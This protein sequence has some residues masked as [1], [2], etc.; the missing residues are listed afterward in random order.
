MRTSKYAATLSLVLGALVVAGAG[1]TGTTTTTTN[2]TNT[3]IDT[4][5]AN[6]TATVNSSDDVVEDELVLDNKDTTEVD[7][8][9]DTE[10]DASAA[11]IS[12]VDPLEGDT[13]PPSFDIVVAVE[14]F[15]LAPDKVEGEN[16][17]GEGH[18][19]VWVDGEYYA[20]GVSEIT[21]LKDLTEGEH[22][23]MVS[24]QNNDHT[25]LATPVK[26]EAVTVTVEAAE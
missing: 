25:D 23:L 5:N 21:A 22:E 12:I 9:D 16:A 7:D 11:T 2:T 14:G 13:V 18:F 26:S 19:H 4:T 6:T 1:C 24:L 8:V 20:P 3:T 10:A 17:E 15:T